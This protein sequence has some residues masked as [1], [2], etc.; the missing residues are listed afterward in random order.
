M[1]SLDKQDQAARPAAQPRVLVEVVDDEHARWPSVLQLLDRLGQ[2]DRLRINAGG[3]LS[4]R[5]S[6]VVAFVDDAPAGHLCFQICPLPDNRLQ[7][8][9]D[10]VGLDSQTA[11]A[12]LRRALRETALQRAKSLKCTDFEGFG[13]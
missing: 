3:W 10:A 6:V 5:Q 13:D 2:R 4:A 11:G 12:H 1:E 9:V 7:A 8:R